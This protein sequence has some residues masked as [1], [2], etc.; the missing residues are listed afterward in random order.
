LLCRI[1]PP[2]D[3][4]QRQNTHQSQED[5]QPVSLGEVGQL[6][7]SALARGLNPVKHEFRDI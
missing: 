7:L 6:S 1:Q 4:Y 2:A 3:E 5:D